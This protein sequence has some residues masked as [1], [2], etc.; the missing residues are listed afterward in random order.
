MSKISSFI[1]FLCLL[2][3]TGLSQIF[4]FRNY[5]YEDGLTHSEV[6]AVCEDGNGN[7]W[8]GTLGGGLLQFDGFN[9]TAYTEESGLLNDFVR[10]LMV[11][12]QGRVWIGTEAGVCLYDGRDFLLPDTLNTGPGIRTITSL[13]QDRHN[14]YWMGTE[15]DGIYVLSDTGYTHITTENGLP[16]EHINCLNQ[17]PDSAIWIGTEKGAVIFD[18]QYFSSL[19]RRDGLPSNLIRGICD[20]GKENVWIATYNGGVSRYAGDSL[21]NYSI[22]QGLSSRRVYA[23]LKDFKGNLWFG[24]DRG[25]TKFDGER[26]RIYN[27]SHGLP[28]NIVVSLFQ[29]SSGSI[30]FGTSGGGLSRLD[31]ERFIYYP[32]NDRMGRRI[33]SL[34]QATNGNMI[35]GSSEGGV[36]VFDGKQYSLLK[37]SGRFTS[38]KVQALFYDPD[39]TLWIGTNDDGA[40]AFDREGFHKYT[41]NEGL[42]GNNISDFTADTAGNIWISTLDSGLCVL[43]LRT[44]SLPKILSLNGLT[45]RKIYCLFADRN[46]NI[47]AGTENEGLY[48]ISLSS[49]ADSLFS[50]A[51]YTTDNGLGNN[52]VKSIISDSFGNKFLGTAGGGITIMTDTAFIIIDK[53]NGLYSNNVY[54]LILDDHNR[55][56]VGTER[57]VD[58]ITFD[59]GFRISECIH[60]GRV[61][62]FRGIDNYRN[63]VCR[64]AEGNIW[65]GTINGVVR[66]CPQQDVYVDHRPETHLSGIK[67]FYRSIVETPFADSL[68]AWYPVP[69]SLKLPH[70]KNNLTFEFIGILLRNPEA[71][72]YRWKLEGFDEDWTPPLNQREVTYSNLPPGDYTFYVTSGNELNQWNEDPV[73]YSFS[74]APPLWKKR[75]FRVTAL[76][77]VVLL[78][79]GIILLRFRRIRKRNQLAQERLEMEKNIIELEQEAARLQMN[80]HFIFN[81]LNSIQGFIASNEPF[82][83]K[84]YLAKFARLMRLILENARE[85]YIPLQNEIDILDNYLELEKLRT[86]DKFDFSIETDQD[87]DPENLDLPPMMLQPFVENAVVHGLSGKAGRGNLTIRFSVADNSL[88]CEIIDDGIGRERAAKNKLQSAS[89]HKSTGISVTKK[90]LQQLKVL[91][92]KEAGVSIED[93]TAEGKPAGTKVTIRIPFESF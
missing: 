65:F 79:T 67:L 90:R 60:F 12:R 53:Q 66:Y 58:R 71:V 76:L 37:G 87:I 44:D 62:G 25:V 7:L 30:W 14:N 28:S 19:T 5:T 63:A 49:F 77:V 46:G 33:F 84:R 15:K 59:I 26:F 51:Q 42:P 55:L 78:I 27:E 10:S 64:D 34:I 57:G 1:V 3:A 21:V 54:S 47:W 68:K 36:T 8:V 93:L 32:E 56:W 18:G 75:W 88:L 13:L 91:T 61:E 73:S 22:D 70:T 9:F 17:G 89:G 4:N 45:G 72:R 52:S 43:S 38:S 82:Q 31:S 20:D 69:A 29:D 81:S 16:D 83:A 50:I 74:I 80:P 6:Y 86:N 24:T 2:N 23:V 40:F 48:K 92:G 39:S 35:F 41:V 85:E 11:D